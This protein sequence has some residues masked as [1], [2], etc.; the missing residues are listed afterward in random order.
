MNNHF[1]ILGGMGALATESF[2]RL[3]NRLADAHSDQDYLD[4]LV[5]NHASIPDRSAYI[6]GES[7]ASPLPALLHDVK[8]A[9]ATNPA[10]IVLTCNTAHVFYDDLAAIADA[11]LLHM[12][13][14][15]IAQ[16]PL[17]ELNGQAKVGFLGTRGSVASGVYARKASEQGYE[18]VLPDAKLQAAITHLIDHDVKANANL[19]FASYHAI[20]AQMQEQGG[21]IPIIL[22][23]TE[24]SLL[25]EQSSSHPYNVID[26]Q[27]ILAQETVSRARALCKNGNLAPDR[28][29]EHCSPA[30]NGNHTS[31]EN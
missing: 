18:L 2:V 27:S 6:L 25:E 3:I 4:Y 19:N 16:L 10:F 5:F 21:N 13:A 14:L 22:G 20:L 26:A 15:T 23:C 12:P 7:T 24:L 1:V 31:T 8:Q 17:A 29:G 30:N 28:R 11:P 9:N